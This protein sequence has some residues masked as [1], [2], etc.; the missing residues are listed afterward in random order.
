MSADCENVPA[1]DLRH[2][3]GAGKNFFKGQGLPNTALSKVQRYLRG[4]RRL[5]RRTDAP[6]PYSADCSGRSVG[7]RWTSPVLLVS[8]FLFLERQFARAADPS[9]VRVRE[10]EREREDTLDLIQFE[11]MA[12][13]LKNA[14]TGSCSLLHKK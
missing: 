8:S 3:T 2:S 1:I 7:E 6:R 13:D 12:K 11:V 14:Q 5:W 9:L 4:P 10:R